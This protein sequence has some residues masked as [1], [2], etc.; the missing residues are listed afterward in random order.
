M[1]KVRQEAPLPL[2]GTLR[3]QRE[4]VRVMATRG[5]RE[6]EEMVVPG[7]AVSGERRL[8]EETGW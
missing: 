8:K 5:K 3:S 2:F 7:I 1:R 4:Q 6:G